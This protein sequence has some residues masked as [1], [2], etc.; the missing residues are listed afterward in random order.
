MLAWIMEGDE[1]YKHWRTSANA[2]ALR[3]SE[4]Y[5]PV[6][7]EDGGRTYKCVLLKS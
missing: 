1:G 4:F 3:K 2:P 7:R 6:V 5:Q